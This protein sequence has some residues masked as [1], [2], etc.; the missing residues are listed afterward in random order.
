M[1]CL[2]ANIIDNI[3]DSQLEQAVIMQIDEWESRT[4]RRLLVFGKSFTDYVKHQWDAHKEKKEAEKQQRVT[5]HDS[6]FMIFKRRRW[7]NNSE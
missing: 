6:L 5:N 7:R 3:L 4:G 2:S 1:Q